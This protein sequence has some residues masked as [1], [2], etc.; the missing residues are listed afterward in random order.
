MPGPGMDIIGE[1]EKQALLEVIESG[2]LYR[3]GDLKDPNF[4]AKVWNLEQD[5]AKYVGTNYALAVTSGT[6][7]LLTAL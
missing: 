3:Y 6:T 7:A 2:Y 1:E 4:K 5:F